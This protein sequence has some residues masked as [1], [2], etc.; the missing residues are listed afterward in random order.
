MFGSLDGPIRK[1]V[2]RNRL[3][4]DHQQRKRFALPFGVKDGRRSHSVPRAE[5]AAELPW[6]SV[7]EPPEP[8]VK[9][10]RSATAHRSSKASKVDVELPGAVARRPSAADRVVICE[11]ALRLKLR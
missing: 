10:D 1:S 2:V 5:L 6:R 11:P 4:A 3:G 7:V 8:D 9:A